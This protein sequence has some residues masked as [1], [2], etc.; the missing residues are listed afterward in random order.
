MNQLLAISV[1]ILVTFSSLAAQDTSHAIESLPEF[2]G[3]PNGFPAY[4]Q[5]A[6]VYPDSAIDLNQEGLVIVYF[7]VDSTGKVCNAKIIRGIAGAPYLDQEALRV[8][9][10]M[11]NWKPAVMNGK[12]F[13]MGMTVPVRFVITQEIADRRKKEIKEKKKAD[14]KK[15][16]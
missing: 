11:P 16:K 2:P 10:A 8:I 4:L 9:N 13:K 1:F 14:K 15:S 3:G 7:D 6:I 5:T 12:P